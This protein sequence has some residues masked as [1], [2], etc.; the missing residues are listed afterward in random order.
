MEFEGEGGARGIMLHIVT[1]FIKKFGHYLEGQFVK[2]STDELKGGARIHYI[3]HTT[4]HN[5]IQQIDPLKSLTDE[6]IR[7][8]IRNCSALNPTLFVEE[9][10]ITVLMKQQIARLEEPSLQCSEMVYEEMRQL[11]Y[12]IQFSELDRFKRLHFLI[13]DMMCKIISYYLV[14]TQ[15]MIRNLIAI[16]DAYVNVNNPDFILPRD[17][18]LNIFKK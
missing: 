17:A 1:K 9:K 13:M 7:T 16:V 6:D 4:L 8:C 5:V 11:V 10:A 15:Q 12:E 18:I 14:P 2:E 3:F